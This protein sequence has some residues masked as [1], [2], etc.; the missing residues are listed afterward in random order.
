MNRLLSRTQRLHRKTHTFVPRRMLEKIIEY[1]QLRLAAIAKQPGLEARVRTFEELFIR[2]L[3]SVDEELNREVERLSWADEE[4]RLTYFIRTRKLILQDFG[5]GRWLP[6]TAV[7]LM[8]EYIALLEREIE[9]AK[10]EERKPW[11]NAKS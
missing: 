11:E 9:I 5:L 8:Q 7:K 3:G 1:E 10:H 6:N 4:A 2:S